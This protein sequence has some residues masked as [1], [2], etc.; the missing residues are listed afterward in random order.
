[1]LF[2][3]KISSE[4]KAEKSDRKKARKSGAENEAPKTS[5]K[6]TRRMRRGK[7]VRKFLDFVFLPSFEI[8]ESMLILVRCL[9]FH[10][11]KG[12]FESK[13]LRK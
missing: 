7:D 11:T 10:E 13:Y 5:E 2:I 12:K 8:L 3:C 1:M 4:K 9:L 6:P